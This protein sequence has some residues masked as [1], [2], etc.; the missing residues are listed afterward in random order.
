MDLPGAFHGGSKRV[1]KSMTD[2]R[3]AFSVVLEGHRCVVWVSRDISGNCRVFLA[4][5]EGVTD[6]FTVASDGLIY[7]K[8]DPWDFRRIAQAFQEVPEDLQSV[9]EALNGASGAFSGIPERPQGV[10]LWNLQ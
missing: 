7:V 6:A 8:W 9:S 4:N 1:S 5:V 2:F 10:T 3:D